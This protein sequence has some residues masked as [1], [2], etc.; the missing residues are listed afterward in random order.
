MTT[1]RMV[2]LGMPGYKTTFSPHA[3]VSLSDFGQS[4][5]GPLFLLL[6][7]EFIII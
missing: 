6:A 2:F 1:G 4:C 3:Q 5:L 7:K